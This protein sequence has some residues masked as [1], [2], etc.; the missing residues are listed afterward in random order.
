MLR[1][2]LVFTC[3]LPAFTGLTGYAQE[4]AAPQPAA[5]S[6]QAPQQTGPAA[7]SA[8]APLQTAPSVP[9]VSSAQ[10]PQ[11]T[12]PS[13]PAP[14][15]APDTIDGVLN[16]GLT[17]GYSPFHPVIKTGKGSTDA[18][19]SSFKIP[20]NNKGLAGAVI[21]IPA[22]QHNSVRISYFRMQG[23]GNT[24]AGSPFSFFA[25]GFNQGDNVSGSFTLQNAKASLDFLSWPFPLKDSKFRV[26]TLWEVQFTQIRASLAAPERATTDAD[27]NYVANAG[28]G[29]EWFI[30]PSFGMG[31]QYRATRSFRWEAKASGFGLPHR[32]AIGDAETFVA[33][34]RGQW[35]FVLGAKAFYFKTSA[36][37]EAYV[38]ALM[39]SAYIGF[40]Y[41]PK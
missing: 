17:Y 1:K 12:A 16:V 33:R 7:P 40:R 6:A 2:I 9:S 11:Q 29:T 5:P 24:V 14:P 15:E 23:N 41:Y 18:T 36:R 30:L 21:S 19:L 27:G 37:R 20:G 28:Q 38:H 34:K 10:A 32:S 3:L 4:P 26:K 8:Q 35:E 25:T 22:G 13:V 31:V 39:P